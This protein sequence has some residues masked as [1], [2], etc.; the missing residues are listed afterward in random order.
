MLVH[1]RFDP[2]FDHWSVWIVVQLSF[3]ASR[4]P[5]SLLVLLV[6]AASFA[7]GLAVVLAVVVL[8]FF[9]SC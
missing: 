7:V 2:V 5:T 9:A 4:Q 1:H 3:A 6:L 8:L